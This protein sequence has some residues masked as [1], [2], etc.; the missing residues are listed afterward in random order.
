MSEI[1][2]NSIT[3]AAGTGAPNF[4]NGL[5]VAGVPVGLNANLETFTSS[6]TWTKPAGVSFVLVEC[7]SGG[8]SGGVQQAATPS[9]GGGSGGMSVDALFIAS[10]VPS[11]V[12]VTVGAG[13]AA[14]SRSTAGFTLAN[15]GGVSSFG[16]LLNSSGLGASGFRYGNAGGGS[17][18]YGGGSG[19]SGINDA[20]S[21]VGKTSL[22][23]GNGG[24]GAYGTS[25]TT[26]SNGVAPGGAGG[27][28]GVTSGTATSGAG[29]R[30]EVRIWTW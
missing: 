29:A 1:R 4:P 22:L 10:A 21:R 25:S 12:S 7:I 15:A 14:V 24:A 30:G 19:G 27:G 17:T 11:S 20:P 2:A 8:E 16:S 5:D 28:C 18:T 13:G 3:D 26:A 23:G 9:I 6:G